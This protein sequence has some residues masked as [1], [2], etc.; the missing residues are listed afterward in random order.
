MKKPFNLLNLTFAVLMMLVVLPAYSQDTDG[1]Y[2][3]ISIYHINDQGQEK[4]VDNY[5]KNAFIPAAHSMGI[6]HV[7][8]FKPVETDS[9]A[10][11]LIYVLVPFA[12]VD[13]FVELPRKLQNDQK[14]SSNGKDYVDAAYDNPPYARMETMLLKAF[15]GMT[16]HKVPEL[17]GPKSKRVYELRSYEGP[18]EKLYFNKVKMFNDGDEVGIFDKLQFNSIF[19]GEVVAGSHMPNLMYMT[20]FD[21]ME[22]RDQHWDAF[23]ADPAWKTLSAKS[24]YKNNVSKSE[25]FLLHPTDYSDL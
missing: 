11:K 8:V 20:S 23:R 6:E 7:G 21:N 10:G 2:Y 15:S 3:Q 19:Y 1:E 24:E 17:K 25:I 4:R 5:L 12:S 14:H 9:T 22:S 18:T 13:Q 16:Q